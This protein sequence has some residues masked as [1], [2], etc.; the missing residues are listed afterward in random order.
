MITS[1]V[2]VR[3]L[4]LGANVHLGANLLHRICTTYKGGA[5]SHPDAN[6]HLS[7]FSYNTVYMT[8]I[9]PRCKFT[10]RVY[11]C[12]GVYI[13]HMNKALVI[14]ITILGQP[15]ELS[16][17]TLSANQVVI[18]KIYYSECRPVSSF[19]SDEA[20]IEITVTGQGNEYIDLRSSRMLSRLMD[21]R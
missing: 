3:N 2:H 18:Q 1:C 9:H 21:H 14:R 16:I 13:V 6:L 7:A 20:P 8:K 17:F 4:H 15:A 19:Q 10:P 5:N 12:T 11:I